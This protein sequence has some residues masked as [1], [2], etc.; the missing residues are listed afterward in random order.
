VAILIFL[1]YSQTIVALVG[2]RLR[3]F[4]WFKRSSV[5][6]FN[7]VNAQLSTKPQITFWMVVALTAVS[8]VWSS[9]VTNTASGS[10]G[11]VVKATFFA[12]NSN[13]QEDAKSSD[14]NASILTWQQTDPKTILQ[15]Y[16]YRVVDPAIFAA[17][18]GIY[19]P[20]TTYARYSIN[21]APDENVPLTS[22]G[23]FLFSQHIDVSTANYL[24]RQAS[25][26][27][28]QLLIVL[29]F[30]L[31]LF[32]SRFLRRSF[33]MQFFLLAA[34]NLLMLGAIVTLPVLSVQYGI[35]RAFQQSL[36]FLGL[37]IVI[38][39][40]GLLIRFGKTTGIII[41]TVLALLFFLSETGVFTQ[42]FGGYNPQLNLNNS[43]LYYDLYYTHA[44]DIAGIR[45]LIGETDGVTDNIQASTPSNLYS[46]AALNIAP[47]A[48]LSVFNDI[49]PALVRTNSYVY[50][51]FA[52]VHND[53]AMVTYD[54]TIV[55]YAY[56]MQ[57]LDDTKDLVYSN[58][59][60]KI[61]R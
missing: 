47:T 10:I 23:A 12:I 11:S 26:K 18:E 45:W 51:G 28:L 15:Q 9:V 34:G 27:L 50:L 35:L 60:V 55:T 49:F 7:P 25:A 41:T 48:G 2:P 21:T 36:M 42:I 5:P 20:I 13:A 46:N 59:D 37:F 32:S 16:I 24:F 58:S 29:G 14:V 3:T 57:F 33:D 30:A 19:Y 8:F 53:R 4:R 61:Y 56:P 38:G 44:S 31:V 39:C 43:G 17:P 6:A 52:T 22:L 54:G 1:V 40:L